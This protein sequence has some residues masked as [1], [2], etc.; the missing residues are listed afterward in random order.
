L[1]ATAI[2]LCAAPRLAAADSVNLPHFTATVELPSGWSV[3]DPVDLG[4]DNVLDVV[5]N[6]HA[7][8]MGSLI[9]NPTA[10]CEEH[11]DERRDD[12]RLLVRP[13]Y[14]PAAYY[15]NVYR[16]TDPDYEVADLC[17]TV[18][19][20][21]V[22]VIVHYLPEVDDATLTTEVEPVLAAIANNLGSREAE[23]APSDYGSSSS[24]DSAWDDDSASSD[25]SSSS[26][27]GEVATADPPPTPDTS[28][29]TPP[30]SDSSSS[31]SSSDSPRR[32]HG[33]RVV[34][35]LDLLS[36]DTGSSPIRIGGGIDIP[37]R[38]SSSDADDHGMA[39]AAS[40]TAASTDGSFTGDA[41]VGVGY[42]LAGDGWSLAGLADAG[43]DRTAG[44]ML[45]GA[46]GASYFAEELQVRV[47]SATAIE[48]RAMAVQRSSGDRDESRY[49]IGISTSAIGSP[50][51]ISLEHE[52]WGDQTLTGVSLGLGL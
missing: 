20:G 41:R 5:A 52:S 12:Q 30:P 32:Y 37:A 33:V 34:A 39:F 43:A 23:T 42:R 8:V 6:D 28:S 7:A 15:Q 4:H 22:M 18:R 21:I 44:G 14:L 49:S 19:S 38:F 27:S 31:S 11:F 36:T 46:D 17:L 51:L 40:A 25:G 26:G 29:Y 16:K 35:F 47:G 9:P 50:M 1:C 48:G 3:R 2:A 13:A 10:T 45:P 24:D